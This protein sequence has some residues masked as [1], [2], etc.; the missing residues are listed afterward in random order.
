MTASFTLAPKP[1][2]AGLFGA[3]HAVIPETLARECLVLE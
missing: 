2:G 1:H 3:A